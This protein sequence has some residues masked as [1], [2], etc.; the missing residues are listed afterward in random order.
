MEGPN[1]KPFEYDTGNNFH[2][3]PYSRENT[4]K[5]ISMTELYQQ[6]P[7]LAVYFANHKQLL[8]QQSEKSKSMHRGDEFYA[9]SKIGPYTFAPYI[10][11]ARDNSTF[12]ASVILP[13]MTPW[14]ELK[15]SICV[16]HTIIISQ[17]TYGNFI[18]EDEAH[19]INGILNSNIVRAYIHSTFKTNG[20]SLKKSHLYLPKYNPQNDIQAKIAQ[21]SREATANAKDRQRIMDE[22]TTEYLKL[23]SV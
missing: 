1:V 11:A 6:S 9:L 13:T 2:I 17:D 20:F 4:Q 5:P 16:K 8:D 3:I 14:G 18:S 19:Y 21:L 22:L 23:C 12:C 10:V 7:K 15:Q